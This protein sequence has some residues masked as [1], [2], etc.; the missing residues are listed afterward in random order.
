[1]DAN[2][3]DSRR[4]SIIVMLSALLFLIFDGTVLGISYRI[5]KQVESDTIAINI[6][7]RQRMLTQQISKTLFQLR[8]SHAPF[9]QTALWQQLQQSTTRF[10][11][12]LQAL[13][14]GGMVTAGDGRR[15]LHPPIST[16]ID[17]LV[18]EKTI[19]IWQPLHQAIQHLLREP[20]SQQLEHAVTVTTQQNL[21]LLKY[22]GQLTNQ[23][24]D[25]SR[26]KT[27][28]LRKLQVVAFGLALANFMVMLH[29]LRQR[30][31]NLHGSH[32]AMKQQAEC[33]HLT[34]L[35]NR[36]HLLQQL[37]LALSKLSP[38]K[39]QL[40]VAF[41]D[42]NK[43]K[44][45]NDR[46]GHTIGDQVLQATAHRLRRKLRQTD[47]IARQGGDEFVVMIKDISSDT[48]AR[49]I[50]EGLSKTLSV[51]ITLSSELRLSIGVSI[52]AIITDHPK[53]TGKQLLH[54]ADQLMYQVK[55]D[56]GAWQIARFD[57]NNTQA[58]LNS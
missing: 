53:V 19:D 51:P 38:G 23:I 20:N 47:L 49:P 44:S 43:F 32:A 48:Q 2:S 24:E 12:T 17:T 21:V 26:Y 14:K 7:G 16:A 10:D 50:L 22:A 31:R 8:A 33:D 57:P 13:Y 28:S 29:S 34:G 9:H 56:Q 40:I 35:A 55:R 30:I 54:A 27:E 4:N 25:A 41:L 58:P 52:G 18:I 5:A 11:E 45:I 1:M 3:T 42:L 15:I 46:Y 6:A 39:S 36:Q 37:D